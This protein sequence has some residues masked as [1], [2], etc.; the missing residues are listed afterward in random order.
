MLAE[1]ERRPADGGNMKRTLPG[2]AVLVLVLAAAAPAHAGSPGHE[3]GGYGFQFRLGGFLPAG[4]GQLWDNNEQIFTLDA[5]DFNDAAL[6]FSFIAGVSN[7]IEVGFNVDWY[8]S[9]AGSYDRGFEGAPGLNPPHDTTLRLSPVTFD[10]RFLPAGRYSYRGKGQHRVHQ[11][12]PYF[13]AG[14]GLLFWNYDENG[15]FI[16]QNTDTGDYENQYADMGDDGTALEVHV[17]AGIEIPMSPGWNLLFEGRYSWAD[18]DVNNSYVAASEL[19]SQNLKLDGMYFF[20]GASWH[21]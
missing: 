14:I 4:G 20:A 5:S 1:Q 9:T 15:Y 19:A 17:L 10:F 6:G 21:F 16:Y 3:P 12:V 8:E 7:N 18:A 13:G 2:I 11:P